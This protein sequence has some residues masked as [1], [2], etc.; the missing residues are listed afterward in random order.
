MKK[1]LE[2][3]RKE[4]LDKEDYTRTMEREYERMMEERKKQTKGIAE[5]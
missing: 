1:I 3:I 2:R 4:R 5:R